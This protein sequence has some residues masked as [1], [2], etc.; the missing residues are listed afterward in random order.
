[1]QQLLTSPDAA[2]L[3][4]ASF[5]PLVIGAST[6]V[7]NTINNWVQGVCSTGSCTN[8]TLASIITNVTAS[9]SADLQAFGFTSDDVQEVITVVQAAYPT[10]REAACLKNDT[11]N[12]LCISETITNVETVVGQLQISDL[13]FFNIVTD[14]QKLIS[15]GVQTIVCTSCVK[16]Q[17]TTLRAQF[18]D[19]ITPVTQDFQQFCG[20]SFVDGAPSDDISQTAVSGVFTE[21]KNGALTSRNLPGMTG[22]ALLVVSAVFITL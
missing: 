3:N 4:P 14:I 7:P 11:T 17:Y 21:Q 2:C 19:I 12:T 18:P 8:A 15:T 13:S 20:S 16:A 22:L 6:S 1:M 5:L 9:C 10:V